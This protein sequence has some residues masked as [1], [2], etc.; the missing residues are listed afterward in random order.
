[1]EK[2]LI[3]QVKIFEVEFQRAKCY[4]TASAFARLPG[5][6]K[7]NI[8]A[9]HKSLDD[10]VCYTRVFISLDALSIALYGF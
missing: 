3:T 10:P 8:R 7:F 4:Y 5:Y 9:T 6:A 2:L 1:V